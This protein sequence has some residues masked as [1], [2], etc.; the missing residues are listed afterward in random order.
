MTVQIEAGSLRRAAV[1]LLPAVLVAALVSAALQL[2]VEALPIPPGSQVPNAYSGFAIA[3]TAGLLLLLAVRS[4]WPRWATPL[5]WG[6]A[7]AIGTLWLSF[8]LAGSRFYLG[9]VSWDQT[10][11]VQYLARLAESP[12]LTD[13]NYADLPPF[14]PAGW[15]WV[16]GRLAD[17]FGVP[18]YEFYKP[19]AI[20]TVAVAAALV[21]VLWSV[22]VPRRIALLLA[23]ATGMVAIRGAAYEPYSWL[24]LAVIPPLAAIAWALFRDAGTLS[25]RTVLGAVL[26]IGGFLGVSAAVY[27]LAFGFFGFLLAVF[28]V[29]A[30]V[31]GRRSGRSAG[32]VLRTLVPRVLGI[33][34]AALP[35]TLLLWTPYLLAVLRDPVSGSTALR[36]LPEIGALLPTPML[37]FSVAGLVCLTGTG[38]LLLAWRRS[39]L[40]RALSGVVLA[41]YAWY[42]ISTAALLVPL[43]LLPFRVEPLLE[44]ALWCAGALAATEVLRWLLTRFGHVFDAV[45]APRASRVLQRNLV[46]GVVAVLAVV[47]VGQEARGDK[48]SLVPGYLDAAAKD[49]DLDGTNALADRETDQDGYWSGELTRTIES[50]TGKA[51]TDITL[52]TTFTDLLALRPYHG[53]QTTISGWAN[54]LADYLGR[55]E[56]IDTW[57]ASTDAASFK[58]ALDESRFRDPEA[59]VF[60]RSDEGYTMRVSFDIFPRE[61]NIGYREVTF[62]AAL[63]DDPAFRKQDVGP[64]TVITREG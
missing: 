56:Q 7:G 23:V 10:P 9:G 3:A 30:L 64:F 54:P 46:M 12:A 38:W 35:L 25:R 43:T 5:A 22:V 29:A 40:A 57:A 63:F 37:D 15:F 13:L 11:R 59:F 50:M 49:Y 14:Y 20:A 47:A 52:L 21:F 16:G 61:P 6:G 36:Y 4:H 28:A 62:D 51:P 39:A 55:N 45:P 60:R 1:E 26:L 34:V 44:V 42:A 41:C 33:G 2:L 53:F 27:T 19:Y 18:G 48:R 17:L 31:A 58:K 24:T 8:A 32:A